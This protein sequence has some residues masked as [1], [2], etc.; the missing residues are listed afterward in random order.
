[1]KKE[2]LQETIKMCRFCFMCRHACPTF[3]ATRRDAHTPRGY[4]LELSAIMAGKRDWDETTVARF[5]QCSQCGLCR[6]DCEF[7][8]PEDD[9]VQAAR[10]LIVAAGKQ[11]EIVSRVAARIVDTGSPYEESGEGNAATGEA[12]GDRPEVLY[13][14]GC[15]A[16]HSH[17]E[18]TRSVTR[19]L[20]ATG[21]NWMRLN[22]EGCCGTPL[23][24]LGYT[25]E[26]KRVAANL[27]ERIAQTGAKT[28]LTGC[29]HCYR[30]FKEKFSE[31]GIALPADMRVLHTTE[32]LQEQA[33]DTLPSGAFT[34]LQGIGYHDP[35]Q[36]GRKLGVYDAPRA[37]LE[38]LS[39][40]T[41]IELFHS[42]NKA[43]CCGAGASMLLTY[44]EVSA[45]I[46][47]RRIDA[48]REE[49]VKTLVTA[50]QN[51][52]TVL[53]QAAGETIKVLDLMELW[54]ALL[55]DGERG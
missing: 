43:E 27:A 18:I 23:Y 9:L 48:A 3:L 19:I 22:D 32:Y 8:W 30:A 55:P 49:H 14:A 5:Y 29:P 15:A 17:P 31:W 12:R 38:R 44:P 37:L 11:P 1:M 40:T 33:V 25:A 54:S 20:D 53:S 2:T 26:A 52:K 39:G 21:V 47:Q 51:C 28:L 10:E 7:H 50:C 42:R 46:A 16:R 35:C 13:F 4:A 45:Q 41:P 6:E 24:E 36:L 34:D